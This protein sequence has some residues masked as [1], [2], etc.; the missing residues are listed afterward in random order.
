[1]GK[2][3]DSKTIFTGSYDGRICAWDVATGDADIISDNDGSVV[4]FTSSDKATWSIYQDDTLK[5]I[6]LSKLSLGCEF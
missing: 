1:M 4:Q 6:D 3:N 5:D 2:T